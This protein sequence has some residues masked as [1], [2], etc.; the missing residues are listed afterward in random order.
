MIQVEFN[1]QVVDWLETMGFTEEEGQELIDLMIATGALMDSDPA[2][3]A[4]LGRAR[5]V[6]RQLM[7]LI[8]GWEHLPA[9]PR[10]LQDEAERLAPRIGEVE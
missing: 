4:D 10:E 1:S 6:I 5:Y 7:D 2:L 3:L 9:C 8:E